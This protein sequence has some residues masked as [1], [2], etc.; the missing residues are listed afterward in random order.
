MGQLEET[1]TFKCNCSSKKLL[2]AVMLLGK[3]E[4]LKILKEKEDVEARCEW[5]GKDL[6]VTPEEVRA[7]MKSEE[8]KE[9][10]EMKAASPRQLKL[11]EEELQAMP[12][13]G[14]ADWS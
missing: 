2:T 1:A 13:P 3:M 11:Q 7:H 4:V 5:C 9:Q 14:T 6:L 8:G 10:V 12:E